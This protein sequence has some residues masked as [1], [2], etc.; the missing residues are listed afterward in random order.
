M[1][2]LFGDEVEVAPHRQRAWPIVAALIGIGLV[3]GGIASVV[4][5]GG[6]NVWSVVAPFFAGPALP[7]VGAVEAA[8]GVSLPSGTEVE[9]ARDDSVY[10]IGQVRLPSGTGNP[11]ETGYVEVG[12]IPRHSLEVWEG[13]LDDP[14]FYLGSEGRSALTGENDGARVIVFYEND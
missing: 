8:S 3:F 2:D 13:E 12:K 1:S 6:V 11:L 10:L 14:R 5:T 7:E 4:V 9:A